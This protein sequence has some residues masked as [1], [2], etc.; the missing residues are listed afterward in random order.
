MKKFP[1]I[2]QFRD[3]IKYLREEKMGLT[4]YT[5]TI[6]LHGSNGALVVPA[7]GEMAFQSRNRVITVEDDNQGFAAAMTER[8]EDNKILYCLYELIDITSPY[9]D[10]GYEATHYFYGEWCGKGIQTGCG[11]NRSDRIFVIF[12]TLC[13]IEGENARIDSYNTC[14][15][16]IG[17]VWRRLNNLGV[18][19]IKQFPTFHMV[20]DPSNPAPAQH[21]AATLTQMVEDSC[22]V[23]MHLCPPGEGED[24]IGEGIVWR[25]TDAIGSDFWFKTK[26]E[27]HSATK[28]KTI[29]AADPA[30]SKSIEDFVESTVT[31][32]RLCQGIDYL[33]EMGHELSQRSTGEFLKWVGGDILEEEKAVMEASCLDRKDVGKPISIAARNWYFKYLE[34]LATVQSHS[35]ACM[36]EVA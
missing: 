36:E 23:A 21:T 35:D 33:A 12:D 11:I 1:K 29:A 25:P 22:P 3:A 19:H 24:N 2:R 9:D 15:W 7:T 13:E 28:V 18:Y 4:R 27:K 6:K 10:E 31:P 17:P 30:L 8:N 14:F 26:G 5:G 32:V 20:I 34:D 16:M